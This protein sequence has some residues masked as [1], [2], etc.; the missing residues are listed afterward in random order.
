MVLLGR[1]ES[2]GI[3]HDFR[4]TPLLLRR[5][6]EVLYR[7]RFICLGIGY[8]LCLLQL[9]VEVLKAALV[10]CALWH[11]A[12]LYLKE[13][14]NGVLRRLHRVLASRRQLKL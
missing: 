11:L 1:N 5:H 6:S 12:M 3:S 2:F 8:Q 9:D 14:G 4:R 13:D 7:V 10:L